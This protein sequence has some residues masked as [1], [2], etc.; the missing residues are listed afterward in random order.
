MR[1]EKGEQNTASLAAAAASVVAAVAAGVCCGVLLSWPLGWRGLSLVRPWFVL[2][3]VLGTRTSESRYLIPVLPAGPNIH[4][5]AVVG[6]GAV[7][8]CVV[9]SGRAG[10][11]A[12]RALAG[13]LWWL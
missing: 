6:S 4:G 1:L 2:V 7:A 13:S 5:G 9:A 8:G 10:G 11:V 3:W 12:C